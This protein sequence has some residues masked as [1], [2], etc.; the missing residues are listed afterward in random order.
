MM[1]STQY[2]G[3]VSMVDRRGNQATTWT[4]GTPQDQVTIFS[5]FGDALHGIDARFDTSADPEAQTRKGQW[6]RA[7][8]QIVDALFAVEGEGPGAQF[9]DPATPRILIAIIDLLREQLNANC[10]D[11]E[12]TGACPWAKVELGR[13]TAETISGPLF[14]ASMDVQEALR[15]H[16]PSRRELGRF[17]T[18]L[19]D[20][21][22]NDAS[23]QSTLASLS[24]VV[25]IVANDD[26]F[27]PIF[28]AMAPMANPE[29]DPDGAGA[30]FTSM[31]VMKALTDDRYDPHHVLDHVFPALVTP[32]DGGQGPAPIE[33]ILDTIADVNRVDAVDP[34]PLAPAD[35]EYVFGTVRDFLIDE[36]RGLEQLYT[37]V[38]NRPRE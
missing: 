8:S 18:Y 37:I 9:K 10:P 25:Q 20:A 13:K 32:M 3:A 16:E 14:A 26:V 23:F 31:A 34:A 5:L 28:Q 1:F 2:A 6:K 21:A 22:A 35:Y 17:L 19:L 36:T 33:V 24:D 30:M 7:R 11:R 29:G 38:Q 12:T 15:A 4:D 27:S